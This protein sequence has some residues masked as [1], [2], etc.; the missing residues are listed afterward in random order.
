MTNELMHGDCK[1]VTPFNETLHQQADVRS[2]FLRIEV[3]TSPQLA[4]LF[5]VKKRR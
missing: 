5:L 3:P 2:K 1:L 4:V